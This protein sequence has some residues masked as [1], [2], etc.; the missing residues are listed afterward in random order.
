MAILDAPV[1]TRRCTRCKLWYDVEEFPPRETPT[2]RGVCLGCRLLRVVIVRAPRIPKAQRK[3]GVYPGAMPLAALPP[4]CERCG[5]P[6][7][8]IRGGVACQLCARETYLVEALSALERQAALHN[9]RATARVRAGTGPVDAM[10]E[11]G[12]A[13][14]APEEPGSRKRRLRR[15]GTAQPEPGHN[16]AKPRQGNRRGP[17]TRRADPREQPR[18]SRRIAVQ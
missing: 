11:P 10:D 5:G 16:R 2:A 15:S 6:W 3:A 12:I 9:E 7:K 13:D 14:H 17:Y 8:A 4:H 1:Q 18:R